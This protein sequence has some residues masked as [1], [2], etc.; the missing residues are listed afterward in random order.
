MPIVQN[1]QQGEILDGDIRYVLMRPD[2]LMGV[3][4]RLSTHGGGD[5]F[6]ALEASAFAHA[7]ASFSAYRDSASFGAKDFLESSCDIGAS[8][9]WGLWTVE[10]EVSGTRIVHVTNSP[11]AYGHGP[12]DRPVCSPITGVLRAITLVGY[13]E[14]MAVEETAC[15]AQGAA[16][17][18]FRMTR[19]LQSNDSN[20]DPAS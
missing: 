17:C 2:V 3:A 20:G 19:R 4:G 18:R 8:L 11:F 5:F 12:A 10:P 9:G 16:R 6:A 14:E 15:A 7:Q 13:G 1:L